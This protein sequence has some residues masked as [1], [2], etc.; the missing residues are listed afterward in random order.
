MS[1][2]VAQRVA[3]SHLRGF[4]L[5]EVILAL[6][7]LFGAMAVLGELARHGLDSARRARDTAVAQL[8]AESKLDEIAAGAVEPDPVTREPLGTVER[9]GEVD[10]L[11]SIALEPT[12]ERG[13]VALRVT[14][15]QDLPPERHGVAISVV[16]WMLDPDSSL[17][18]D[19]L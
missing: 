12:S 10:W 16:R 1:H 18:E 17:F 14:I 8:L 11:C 4:S 2:R 5:L 6:A 19:E 9:L 3:G 7:I 13:L 15:E